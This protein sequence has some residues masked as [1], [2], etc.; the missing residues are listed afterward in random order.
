MSLLVAGG[1]LFTNCSDDFL[2]VTN[3]NRDYL[4]DYY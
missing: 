1:M 4:E 3:P 2:E